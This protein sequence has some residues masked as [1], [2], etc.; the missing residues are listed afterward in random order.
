M[1]SQ[2]EV[3]RHVPCGLS[4]NE[5]VH[6]K[7]V[8]QDW[9]AAVGTCS[10][11]TLTSISFGLPLRLMRCSWLMAECLTGSY[12]EMLLIFKEGC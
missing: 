7:D 10:V 12:W 2:E 5:Q 11:D 1:E 9:L 8:A 3:I 6:G 4:L